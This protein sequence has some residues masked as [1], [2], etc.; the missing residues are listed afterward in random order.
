MHRGPT[1]RAE[2]SLDTAHTFSS[3]VR[4]GSRH[5]T[6]VGSKSLGAL[7]DLL[8]GR[9]NRPGTITIAD[10]GGR[11]DLD[12]FVGTKCLSVHHVSMGRSKRV[13]RG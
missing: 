11:A 1:I 3:L 10:A 2:E 8:H 4:K 13:C 9:S 6:K 5:E 7:L 12:D